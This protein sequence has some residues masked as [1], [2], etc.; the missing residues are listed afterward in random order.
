MPYVAPVKEM[1][2]VMNELAGLTEVVA[3]PSYAKAGADGEAPENF[4]NG[5]QTKDS[6][7]RVWICQE[8]YIAK[9]LLGQCAGHSPVEVDY[10]FLMPPNEA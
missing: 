10:P 1:L 4:V 8:S 9:I 2:F 6:C 7:Q 3:Y 5:L